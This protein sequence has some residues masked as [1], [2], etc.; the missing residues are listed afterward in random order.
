MK[1]FQQALMEA[2]AAVKA[3][4]PVKALLQV[5]EPKSQAERCY[6]RSFPKLAAN[7]GIR[8][9]SKIEDHGANGS[10]YG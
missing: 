4:P 6:A 9:Q 10:S 2:Y 1:P 3:Q 5:M 8:P 7:Q